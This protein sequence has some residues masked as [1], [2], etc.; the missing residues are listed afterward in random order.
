MSDILCSHN[1]HNWID[2]VTGL[3]VDDD[4]SYDA[5]IIRRKF[6]CGSC[7]VTT[8][9]MDRRDYARDLLPDVHKRREF[10]RE[11]SRF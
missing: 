4:V 3:P 2:I 11:H 1:V 5:K 10:E 9:Y 7:G 6:I 8:P